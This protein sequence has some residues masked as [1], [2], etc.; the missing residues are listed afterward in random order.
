MKKKKNT[1]NF[2]V[3]SIYLLLAF[4]S[5]FELFMIQPLMAKQIL[6][7]F[8]G[9]A[10]VW[11]ACLLFFQVM[12]FIGYFYAYLIS[13]TKL[14]IQVITHIS[15]ICSSL[16]L[17][18][19]QLIKWGTPITP[20]RDQA[21]G[22]FPDMPTLAVVTLLAV[23]V[24]LPYIMLSSTS[25]LIQSWFYGKDDDRKK[26]LYFFYA[27]SNVGSL[28]ALLF[29]PLILEP[30]MGVKHQASAWSFGYIAFAAVCT[31]CAIHVLRT[32]K[33]PDTKAPQRASA[34][35]PSLPP[36]LS[37]PS[38][39]KSPTTTGLSWLGLSAVATLMLIAVTN[40]ICA[41]VAP[42]PLLWLLPLSLYLLAFII[43]FSS[44]TTRI[45]TIAALIMLPATALTLFMMKHSLQLGI[46]LQLAAFLTA[47]FCACMLCLG[48]LH[49]LRPHAEHLTFFYL[50]IAL[51]GAI[52]GIFTGVIAPIIFNDY[53]ELRIGLMITCAL[54]AWLLYSKSWM[55][56]WK[57]PL[58][59]AALAILATLSHMP[60]KK[61]LTTIE[62][63]RSFY[64]VLKVVEEKQPKGVNVYSLMHGKICHGLQFDSGPFSRLPNAYFGPNSGIGVA[65]ASHPKR[66]MNDERG[67]MNRDKQRSDDHPPS[68]FATTA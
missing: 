34:S 24:G 64:G 15:L 31:A 13:F 26:P 46:V 25:P 61:N 60:E 57:I 44:H 14:K 52:G 27:V 51:G 2:A 63:S 35:N 9:A 62:K 11:T 42:V 29:Y 56:A 45:P 37:E 43:C 6:P 16:G 21:I 58:I 32:Q 48:L 30:L 59:V 5:A 65:F 38:V 54:A 47:L 4:L 12:L 49:K 28:L 19:W 10:A 7:W 8:G 18:A 20:P 68:H 36:S 17:L 39:V 66:T 41:N 40:E 55:S 1:Q 53:R 22:V 3:T 33:S 50:M 23:A 67:T